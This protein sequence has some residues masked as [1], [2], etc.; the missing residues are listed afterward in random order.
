MKKFTKILT[1]T[2]A[3]L[4]FACIPA[5]TTTVCTPVETAQAATYHTTTPTG[6]TQ[7]SDVSYPSSGYIHNWGARGEDCVFLSGKAQEFYTGTNTF[8]EFSKLSGNSNTS[9]T[10]SSALY[11]AL[12]SFM[13]SKHKYINSYKENNT[14]LSYTDCT[15]ESKQISSFYSGKKLGPAW[16]SAATWNKEHT[17]PNSK[18]LGGSDEDD[19]MMIR[20]TWVQ[21][22]SSRGNT[23]YGQSNNYYDPNQSG[24]NVRGDCARIVLYNYTR[25]GNTSYMWGTSGVMES[26]AVLLQ[27][28]QEDPVDTWEMG[29]NDAVQS[30][31]GTRNVFVD[32]P[33]LAWLLFS[34]EI[35][36]GINTPSGIANGGVVV[37]PVVNPDD[38]GD[39]NTGDD[40]TVTLP[41]ANSN[42]SI[43]DA[44]AIGSS[45]AHN[46]TTTDKYYVTGKI[47]DVSNTEYGNMT[48]EDTNGNSIYVYGTWS[49]DGKTRYDA[50]ANKPVAGDTVTLYTVIGNYN[51]AQL[52]NAWIT[53]VTSGSAGGGTTTPDSGSSGSGNTGSTGG[54]STVD[55]ELPDDG[56]TDNLPANAVATFDF[57]AKGAAKHVD[58]NEATLKNYTDG[59]YT[60]NI[61]GGVKFYADAYDAKGNSCLKLGSSGSVGSFTFTV[62]QDVTSVTFYVAKYKAKTSA[63]TINSE[64]FTPTGNSD[65]GAYEE[66]TVDTTT[67]KTVTVSTVS[68][69]TRVMI[70]KI[71]F[72]AATTTPDDNTGGTT[73]GS[74]STGGGTTTPDSGTTTPDSGTTTP[75][76]GSENNTPVQGGQADGGCSSAIGGVG[77]GALLVCAVALLKK[78]RS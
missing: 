65:D 51:G 73:P 71:V 62:P 46:T 57:G 38:G 19:V 11:K 59:S 68:G 30:I 44:Y 64:K 56:N 26:K 16:D 70:D 17:W 76:S 63:V 21:E 60:L 7:A 53:S 18:G 49:A 12:K 66:F 45:Y 1:T 52:K 20:P 67:Q 54:G 2:L 3:S 28:M 14:L 36:S 10:P 75:D 23:A 74:G 39:D 58:G 31:T 13:T 50:M 37:P 41:A 55:P 15:H 27:W 42:V 8:A 43:A 22:N 4:A 32:Y 47:K 25:W 61:T 35:P 40:T 34:E 48:I 6:Y 29:R 33:E 5:V 72:L 69:S 24:A 78:K 9:S 77:L